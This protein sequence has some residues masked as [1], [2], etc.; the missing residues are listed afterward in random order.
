MKRFAIPATLLTVPVM[1][2]ASC[3]Q[4][5]GSTAA[6][7]PSASPSTDTDT[8]APAT[9]TPT[10]PAITTTTGGGGPG[11]TTAPAGPPRC[12]TADLRVIDD[13]KQQDGAAGT[14]G[15]VLVFT[16]ISGHICTV[17]G[18]PGVS[19]VAGDHGTQVNVG[20][21]RE[22]GTMT[23][24]RLRP[25]AQAHVQLLIPNYQNWDDSRCKP[26]D[27]RGYRVYPPNETRSIFV[28]LPRKACSVKN[29]GVGTVGPTT[30]GAT[31]R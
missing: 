27:V 1:A 31:A 19:F 16:N 12:H 8:S 15:E 18:Y 5:G 26:V 7:A 24:V 17:Y 11:R 28:S 29:I 6:P 9:P 4:G 2:L 25:G 21:A 20:F 13:P 23:T 22:T 10:T 14:V 30:A 3:G